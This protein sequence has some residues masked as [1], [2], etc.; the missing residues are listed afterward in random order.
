MATPTRTGRQAQTRSVAS[1]RVHCPNCTGVAY[2]P[3]CE[4]EQL[5]S[6]D[7]V[8]WTGDG[9]G[10]C[11]RCG[12]PLSAHVGGWQIPVRS[13]CR[14]CGGPLAKRQVQWCGRSGFGY[15]SLCSVAWSSP[16][17]LLRGL[18]ELQE[19]R[20]G[21]CCLPIEH[22]AHC[23]V[24]HRVPLAAGGARTLDN[25]RAAHRV[26]NQAKKAHTLAQARRR[27]GVGSVELKSRL[28]EVS[29]AAR[30]LLR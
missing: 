26:C 5:A 27:L 3:H 10:M 22:W 30:R 9:R 17:L 13:T 19:R 2:G 29:P 24:D 11:R 6:D 20:C 14:G 25:L 12:E 28:A 18:I 8:V 1:L 15:N 21:V 23:E 4:P 7:D 16:R